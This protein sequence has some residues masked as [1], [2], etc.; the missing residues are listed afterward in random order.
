MTKQ[1]QN[2]TQLTE[3]KMAFDSPCKRARTSKVALLKTD[4]DQR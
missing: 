1:R 3:V 4:K 2:Q